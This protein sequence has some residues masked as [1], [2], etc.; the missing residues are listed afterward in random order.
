MRCAVPMLNMGVLERWASLCSAQPTRLHQA[1]REVLPECLVLPTSLVSCIGFPLRPTLTPDPS[2][3]WR[4]E[5]R[6]APAEGGAGSVGPGR[7]MAPRT[8]S[9]A[10]WCGKG[11]ARLRSPFLAGASAAA[12]A[13]GP[14]ANESQPHPGD[15]HGSAFRTTRHDPLHGR[16]PASGAPALRC[17]DP[18]STL[19]RTFPRLRG[20]GMGWGI[21]SLAFM[22]F[23]RARET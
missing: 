15:A 10:E 6:D 3:A 2:P 13:N 18:C 21:A 1:P 20:K 14:A 23:T 8:R 9:L 11:R 16:I 4:G 19:R 7:W 17:A 22:L 12:P 5:A